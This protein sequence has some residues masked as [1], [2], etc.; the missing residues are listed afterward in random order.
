MN[1]NIILADD[2]EIMR[3]G[4]RSLIE[5]QSGMKV[6]AEAKNGRHAL[7]LANKFNPD[8]VVMDISMPDLNGIEATR[9]ISAECPGTKIVVFSMYSD[10]QFIVGA[11]KAGASGY[12]LKNSAFKELVLAIRTVAKNQTYLSAKIAS[13]VVKEYIEQ[14]TVTHPPASTDLTLREREVL[15]LIAEGVSA[16]SIADRLNVSIKTVQTHRRNI[17]EKLD[18]HSIA[19]LT[20]FAIREG[21]TSLDT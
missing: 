9:L 10:R 17:M 15:Q 7:K 5:K 4:L 20:K 16:Q 19:E 1:L 2:H 6:V 11:L 13:T 8:V 18:I 12:M 21:L 3:D 14:L